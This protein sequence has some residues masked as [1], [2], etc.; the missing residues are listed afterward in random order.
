MSFP[1]KDNFI[2]V[3]DYIYKENNTD[4]K[5][6]IQQI[7]SVEEITIALRKREQTVSAIMKQLAY[8]KIVEKN[9]T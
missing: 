3:Y 1:T 2:E 4:N 9:T 8:L 6:G 7:F 5:V